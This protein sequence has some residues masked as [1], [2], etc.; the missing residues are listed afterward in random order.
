MDGILCAGIVSG[1]DWRRQT[2][3]IQLMA[4]FENGGQ[5]RVARAFVQAW[6]TR[7]SITPAAIAPLWVRLF[8]LTG[9]AC[10]GACS[11]YHTS[12]PEEWWHESVGGKISEQRP[13]PPGDKDPYPN[14]STVPAKPPA[15][16]AAMWNKMTAGLITD[17]IRAD[18]AA[19]LAPIATP[20]T[21]ASAPI[22]SNAQPQSQEPG[23][24]AAFM[25]TEPPR[26]AP[27]G[28]PVTKR[29]GVP[30]TALSGQ[31]GAGA[32][33]TAQPSTPA[34][35]AQRV[36]NGQLP[37]L[38]TGEPPRPNI[39]PA[40]RPPLVPV[41]VT[42]PLAAAPQAGS[43]ELDF[44]RGS[45][46]LDDPALAEVKVLAATRGDRGIAITG[47]GDATSSDP[48]EQSDALDLGLSRANAL[49]TALVAQGVPYARLRLNAEAAGRGASLRLLQ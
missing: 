11:D 5:P 39:A 14:L 1:Y 21:R 40:P 34:A 3:R 30:A 6:R 10:L 31:V 19:A 47:Y 7:T 12:G 23:A 20:A 42:P 8:A 48:V 44:P 13:P 49:A 36:A 17:R 25:G 38:P 4:S 33:E 32:Q 22:S 9:V 28:P 45:A 18:Q 29:S 41:T 24:S 16:N 43:D 26:V 2:G 46:S 37:A 35:A 15:A 27:A